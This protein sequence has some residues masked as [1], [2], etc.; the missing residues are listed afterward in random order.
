MIV[1]TNT[2]Y[3]EVMHTVAGTGTFTATAS[4]SHLLCY[5][6]EDMHSTAE[7]FNSSCKHNLANMLH[8]AAMVFNR[9]LLH[10]SQAT[11]K[12]PATDTLFLIRRWALSCL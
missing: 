11:A 7:V 2:Y 9:R 3:T 4:V 6:E 10:K 12:L 5:N 8:G 1:Y